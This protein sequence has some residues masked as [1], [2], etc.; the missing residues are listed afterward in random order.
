MVVPGSLEK[1]LLPSKGGEPGDVVLCRC[2]GPRRFVILM[3]RGF[4]MEGGGQSPPTVKPERSGRDI[5]CISL[6]SHRRSSTGRVSEL[7]LWL[8]AL[9]VGEK[10]TLI[11]S[12]DSIHGAH[13]PVSHGGLWYHPT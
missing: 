11:L 4:G 3:Q 5:I 1:L 2:A 13:S 7:Q 9:C 8:P 6:A 12:M 10:L